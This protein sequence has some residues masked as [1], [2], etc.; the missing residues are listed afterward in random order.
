[1][2]Q[3]W[4][5][6]DRKVRK[7]GETHVP[8]SFCPPQIPRGLTWARTRASAIRSRRRTAWAVT[9][10]K[11]YSLSVHFLEQ[12]TDRSDVRCSY[13]AVI[14]SNMDHTCHPVLVWPSIS[15]N[16]SCMQLLKWNKSRSTN[17]AR[18]HAIAQAVRS[19]ILT[20][21][22]W[23]RFQNSQRGLCDTGTCVSPIFRMFLSLY[24]HR[25]SVFTHVSCKDG[26]HRKNN[27]VENT[28]NVP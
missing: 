17:A 26:L 22:V 19:R 25:C 12:G 3:R 16:D 9:R 5:D 27:N 15:W 21:D 23:V 11:S 24:F 1:M 20:V 10:S 28:S 2:E 14:S 4:K 8:V 7:I 13:V 6:T 18:G